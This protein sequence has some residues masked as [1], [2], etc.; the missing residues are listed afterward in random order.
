MCG[1]R[2]PWA[3][4]L[5]S[6]IIYTKDIPHPTLIAARPS[7]THPNLPEADGCPAPLGLP[8]AVLLPVLQW[9]VGATGVNARLWHWDPQ[10]GVPC[11]GGVAL[12]PPRPLFCGLKDASARVG[13]ASASKSNGTGWIESTCS[14]HPLDTPPPPLRCTRRTQHRTAGGNG[15]G[16][17]PLDLDHHRRR[18]LAGIV[19]DRF[20]RHRSQEQ[21]RMQA[22]RSRPPPPRRRRPPPTTT[23]AAASASTP[24][25]LLLA[26]V[27]VGG[28]R[29]FQLPP[30]ARL[31]R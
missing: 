16:L 11:G 10:I 21:D 3:C 2:A 20:D 28:V 26:L 9:V 13:F 29:A 31:T 18:L 24:L 1:A 22:P 27:A 19:A 25:L 4:L 6:A 14:I 7:L 5:T 12:G 8:M 23:G 17:P 30:P 15:D